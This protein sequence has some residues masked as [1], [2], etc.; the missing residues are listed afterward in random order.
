MTLYL[1][2]HAAGRVT[3][4]TL[5]LPWYDAGRGQVAGV[6]IAGRTLTVFDPRWRVAGQVAVGVAAVLLAIAV[7]WWLRRMVRWR[8]ARWRGLRA[9]RAA[10]NAVQLARAVRRFSLAGEPE[11]P[12]LA[13]GNGGCSRKRG[14]AWMANW[15]LRWKR[16]ATDTRC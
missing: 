6:E 16:D 2:P 9:I 7:V 1:Q 12:S 8:L 4:P 15:W 11:A 13:H 14:V 3:V 5:R 10:T